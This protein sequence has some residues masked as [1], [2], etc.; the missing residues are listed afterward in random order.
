M[1]NICQNLKGQMA[2]CPPVPPA[3]CGAYWG[4]D[5]ILPYF[6]ELRMYFPIVFDKDLVF[7]IILTFISYHLI[8]NFTR[9]KYL[10][11]STEQMDQNRNEVSIA[12]NNPSSLNKGNKLNLNESMKNIFILI[13]SIFGSIHI[14]RQMFFGYFWP[15]YHRGF[16]C[17]S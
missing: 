16:S 14:W 12:I 5:V 6:Y 8:L 9:T 4:A 2:P 1:A 7:Y 11:K 3:L 13:S 17:G 10:K 15:T